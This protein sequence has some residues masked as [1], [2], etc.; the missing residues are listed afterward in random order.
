MCG[1]DALAPA[2]EA[3]A[4]QSL[5]SQR[6]LTKL[7]DQRNAV[8]QP[9]ETSRVT[10][11]LPYKNQLLD[12]NSGILAKSYAPVRADLNRRLAGQGDT[13]PSGFA[14]QSRIDLDSNRANA[15]DNNVISTLNADELTKENAAAQLNPLGYYG[16]AGS[17]GQSVLS[18]PAVQSGG[19]GNFV[20]GAVSGL[21]NNASVA[22]GG[23]WTL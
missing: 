21:L 18:A 20:G 2:K 16:S 8:Q 13:L 3:A 1:G 5:E 12:Y 7:A 10:G 15:F 11:G 17:S 6:E 19:V 22:S 14:N 9:F 23:A 4:Q